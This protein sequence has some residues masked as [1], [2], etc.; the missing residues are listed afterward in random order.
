LFCLF[1]SFYRSDF[2]RIDFCYRVQIPDVEQIFYRTE[3]TESVLYRVWF[4]R[5]WIYRV[6]FSRFHTEQF[7]QNPV[8]R[9]HSTEFSLQIPVYRSSVSTEVL[10]T[11]LS[12]LTEPVP[13]WSAEHLLYRIL[14][15]AV[16][17]L[18]LAYL[19]I[20]TELMTST[21][22]D[23]LYSFFRFLY[24][25][26]NILFQNQIHVR[27][28]WSTIS[29]QWPDLHAHFKGELALLLIRQI[30]LPKITL[31][32]ISCFL[33]QNRGRIMGIRK[34]LKF[35][36]NFRVWIIWRHSGKGDELVVAESTK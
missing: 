17:F 6:W 5:F 9:I 19:P 16:S 36:W 32:L 1:C 24:S 11:E 22:T 26:A 14:Q 8:C 15:S 2:S 13:F 33:D 10:L 23:G 3:Y 28:E 34:Y 30:L 20:P 31:F 29:T 12:T 7:L 35:L 27:A 4:C 21:T 25:T 18:P